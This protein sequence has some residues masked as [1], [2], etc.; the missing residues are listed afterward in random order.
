MRIEIETP[1]YNERRYGK[2]WI[3]KAAFEGEKLAYSFGNWVGDPGDPG[4]LILDDVSEDDI[5]AKGQK[6]H[7][8]PGG[9]SNL[10]FRV[11]PNAELEPIDK[12]AA[13]KLWRAKHESV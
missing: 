13:Y 8:K 1:S 10:L 3:A 12:L 2:P 4:L 7:R 11:G 9:S 6:D 5:V